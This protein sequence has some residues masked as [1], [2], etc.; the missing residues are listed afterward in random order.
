[1]NKYKNILFLF[2]ILTAIGFIIIIINNEDDDLKKEIENF[3]KKNTSN[4]I[5]M[6][7]PVFKN[8]GVDSEP[9]E[10]RAKK[11]VQ[12]NNDFELYE[13]T[14]K[15]KNKKN[16]MLYIKADY[17]YYSQDSQDIKLK[18]NVLIYDDMGN[19]T[20]TKTAVIDI[21]NKKINL[22]EEVLSNRNKSEIK[23]D[24]SI[25]DDLN[26]VITYSGNVKVKIENKFK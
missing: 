25:I 2:F 18:G 23:S 6:S 3:N 8:K 1:M 22:L 17:G 15:F 7:N 10:I 14:G 20:S 13:I 19:T 24:K 12:I 9:Y 16:E 5:E 26:K 4:N 21:V 11:G